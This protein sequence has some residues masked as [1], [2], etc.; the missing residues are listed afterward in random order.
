MTVTGHAA[1]GSWPCSCAAANA[2]SRTSAVLFIVM[3]A[4]CAAAIVEAQAPAADPADVGTITD[5]VRVSYEVISGPAGTPRQW[6]RD[7]TL[8][9][10]GA[11][12]VALGE[13]GGHVQVRIMTPEEYRQRTN[14]RFVAEGMI[15]TEIAGH[16]ECFGNVAQVRSVY[17]FRRSATGPV[18]A[19]GVN[20]FMLYWDGRRWWITGMA[21]DDERPS[22]PIPPQWITSKETGPPPACPAARR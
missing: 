17:T 12:F 15:E 21:W 2:A 7:S 14:Q 3:L 19:R 4:A 18:E 20:Y 16:I 6:R 8:Y 9:M 1:D 10:P 13:R 22:N 11:T 5:I